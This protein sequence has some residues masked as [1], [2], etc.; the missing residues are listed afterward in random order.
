MPGP[1]RGAPVRQR[2][3]AETV[4]N[5][6]LADLPARRL[7]SQNLTRLG[8]SDEEGRFRALRVSLAAASNSERASASRPARNRKSPPRRRERRIA[9]ERGRVGDLVHQAQDRFR[10]ERHAVGDGA[11][12]IDHGGGHDGA[13]P[14]RPGT[15]VFS[16]IGPAAF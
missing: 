1:R 6:S 4:K 2:A 10:P 15:S 9:A 7:R 13:Q 11:I 12:E 16:G 5:E 14:V 3:G 8:A